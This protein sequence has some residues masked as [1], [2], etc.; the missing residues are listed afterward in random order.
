MQSDSM[1]ESTVELPL[2]AL[3][4]ATLLLREDNPML[5]LELEQAVDNQVRTNFPINRQKAYDALKSATIFPLDYDPFALNCMIL[6]TSSGRRTKFIFADPDSPLPVGVLRCGMISRSDGYGYYHY[7]EDFHPD[8][9]G[10]AYASQLRLN[11]EEVADLRRLTDQR[12]QVFFSE[13]GELIVRDP[14][15][16][17]K[18]FFADDHCIVNSADILRA[19]NGNTVRERIGN[20]AMRR[21][22]DEDIR[23]EADTPVMMRLA[24]AAFGG[25][26][27][28]IN[29]ARESSV[30]RITQPRLFCNLPSPGL[31]NTPVFGWTNAAVAFFDPDLGHI[32]AAVP[33]SSASKAVSRFPWLA[34]GDERCI[35]NM[36]LFDDDFDLTAGRNAD[37]VQPRAKL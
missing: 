6:F 23:I 24:A 7:C 27:L 9:K 20:V 2:Y 37:L 30:K 14:G 18:S 34:C 26:R 3:V 15:L 19:V 8:V 4:F 28:S 29:P 25:D 12:T 10:M 31:P 11:S 5:A 13:R 1:S 35:M 33:I 16:T 36:I 21:I 32:S 17:V 22:D